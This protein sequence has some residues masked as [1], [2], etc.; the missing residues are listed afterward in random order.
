[1]S[2]ESDGPRGIHADVD[3]D[4]FEQLWTELLSNAVA[5]AGRSGRVVTN[6]GRR[7]RGVWLEVRD[8]GPGVPEDKKSQLFRL[9]FTTKPEG[10]GIGLATV[11]K[12][13]DRHGALVE[14]FDAAEG[15]AG[16]RVVLTPR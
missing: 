9:F 1:M 8:N 11:K 16:F 14:V 5:A 7:E 6:W 15:G 12:V 4:L 2:I 10:T 3:P 13:A